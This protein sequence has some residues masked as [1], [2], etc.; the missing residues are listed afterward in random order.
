MIG[1]QKYNA[2]QMF[3]D[4]P[5]DLPD[6]NVVEEALVWAEEGRETTAVIATE[7]LEDAS[8]VKLDY[9]S[10]GYSFNVEKIKWLKKAKLYVVANNVFT[11]T[12]YS[13]ADPEI[14]YSNLAYGWDQY[15]VY[16]NSRSI[17]F[18]LNATF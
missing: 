3:M 6:L 7:Y 9:I 13:G 1:H 10:I 15:N 2:T 11:L 12:K 17:T 14:Y 4:A 16:P 8:F 5:F 18:G